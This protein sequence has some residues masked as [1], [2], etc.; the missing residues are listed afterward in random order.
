MRATLSVSV[1]LAACEDDPRSPSDTDAP[2]EGDPC[3]VP[4]NV[5]RWLGIPGSGAY[6]PDGTD[7]SDDP[8]TGT[9]LFLP[10]DITFAPD[11]TAYYPDY[12][13]H[14]IR[15]VGADGLVR[16][17]SGTGMLGDGPNDSGSVV[18]CWGGCDALASAWNHPTHVAIHPDDAT[19]IYVAA[20]H[21]SRLNHIDTVNGTMS[22]HAGT[23]GRFY[24][25]GLDPTTAL[26]P[27]DQQVF[28]LDLAVLD[29]PSSI[30][31][32]PDGTLYFSDQ[33]NHLV[34]KIAPGSSEIEVFAGTIVVEINPDTGL[35][36][37]PAS[38]RR[39]PG[40]EGD[41]GDALLSKLRGNTDGKS[42]PSSKLVYDRAHNRIILA[43]TMNGVIRAVDLDTN[44]IDTI[45]GKYTSA[46]EITVTDPISG[47]QH[48]EDP[49]SI[50]GYAGD[51]GD[52][53]EAVFSYPRDIAIGIYG[54]I[55]IADTKNNCVRV[56]NNDGTIDRF[57]GVCDSS[58]AYSGDGG[59]ALEAEFSSVYGVEVDA[60]GNVYIADMGN[61]V[62]RRVKR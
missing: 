14:R 9:Y 10:V 39:Q 17:V 21:N 43:D 12:S 42:D 18:N 36:D 31:F 45:A 13:N 15:H 53:L 25:R 23:G 27:P 59:P 56:L 62:I 24:G 60:E 52:A 30:A 40:F 3:E 55:Y 28:R 41:G 32:G 16:T 2:A 29:L 49:A 20:W 46:G 44:V 22:W 19:Q 5:C 6:T 34:R 26:L 7:M 33:A 50:P 37:G 51:G 1:V 35:P 48:T 8:L 4:G 58:D 11:G 54:E 57:A 47:E 61:H 38:I